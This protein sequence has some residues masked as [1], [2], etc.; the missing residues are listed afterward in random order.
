MSGV[1]FQYPDTDGR[2]EDFTA[3][4]DRAHKGGVRN[5]FYPKELFISRVTL[6]GRTD[7]TPPFPGSGLLCL[8][9]A[10]AV[11]AASSWRV[12]GGHC[13]GQLP[14]VRGSSLL[15]RPPRRLLCCQREPG[16]NDA[17]QN[18][19]R[20]QVSRRFSDRRSRCAVVFISPALNFRDAAGKEVYRLALQTR[21]QHIRR[22]KATSN[23][24]TAQVRKVERTRLQP[25]NS[26]AE[27]YLTA[28]HC[29]LVQTSATLC[30]SRPV[31]CIFMSVVGSVTGRLCW[32][33]WPPCT[34]CTTDPRGSST[35]PRGLTTQL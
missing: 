27:Q 34:L 21:E 6:E 16:P 32:P 14:E 20:H 31:L 25:S 8:R 2:V 29:V 4:V 10:G 17:R 13:P 22:D 5:T 15:R 12:W 19:R 11:C 7:F 24:C 28:S 1:L 9:P 30:F 26:R 35:S 3:L 23:I 18:G 33:T